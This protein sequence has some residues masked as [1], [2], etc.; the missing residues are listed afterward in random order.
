MTCA[1][2]S[3]GMRTAPS[4]VFYRPQTT[5]LEVACPRLLLTR[6]PKVRPPQKMP[7]RLTANP[8][9]LLTCRSLFRNELSS[10]EGHRTGLE[11]SHSLGIST[12][13]ES[14]P[15]RVV[16]KRVVHGELKV[17]LRNRPTRRLTKNAVARVAAASF[18][19]LLWQRGLRRSRWLSKVWPSERESAGKAEFPPGFGKSGSDSLALGLARDSG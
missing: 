14:A 7:S 8:L 1:R 12:L 3:G 17:G 10:F 15:K 6:Q 19:F 13:R 2:N 11:P 9:F 16:T 4:R 5:D 18:Y